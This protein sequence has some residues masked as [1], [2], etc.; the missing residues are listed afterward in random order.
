MAGKVHIWCQA[1]PRGDSY[2]VRDNNALLIDAMPFRPVTFVDILHWRALQQPDQ[3]AYTFLRDGKTEEA[4]LTYRALDQQVCALGTL[5]QTLEMTGE[6][7]L[8]LYPPG[9]DYVVSFLSCL[10]AGVIAVPAYPP[11][12]ERSLAR[13]QA[14]VDDAQAKFVLTTQQIL[15]RMRRWSANVP[16]L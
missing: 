16:S 11:S 5:L 15:S 14:T 6:R 7:A 12:S 1:T 4:F 3:R 13:I 2:T 9:L 8:L 10:S